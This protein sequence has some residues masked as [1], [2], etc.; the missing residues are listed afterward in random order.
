METFSSRTFKHVSIELANIAK[1]DRVTGHTK[2]AFNYCYKSVNLIISY[3]HFCK[4]S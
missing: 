2:E 1:A 3:S 4:Y